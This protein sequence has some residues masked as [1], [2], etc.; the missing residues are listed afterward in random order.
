MNT[1]MLQSMP[2]VPG[3]FRPDLENPTAEDAAV[4]FPVHAG[5]ADPVGRTRGHLAC[6]RVPV[7]GTSRDS[8][9]AS[10]CAWTL[11]PG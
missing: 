7:L 10:N 5:D 6:S 9:P 4:T 8:S 11:V 1:D 3:R 2:D